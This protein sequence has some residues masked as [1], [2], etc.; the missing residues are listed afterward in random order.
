MKQ[1]DEYVLTLIKHVLICITIFQV[2][3]SCFQWKNDRGPLDRHLP[4]A[5]ALSSVP[6]S[7]SGPVL[8][9]VTESPGPA[10]TGPWPRRPGSPP[11]P[12]ARALPPFPARS[13]GFRR[14][15]RCPP[16]RQVSGFYSHARR[17]FTV[18]VKFK[19]VHLEPWYPWYHSLTYDIIVLPMIS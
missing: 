17:A 10:P 9:A 12:A 2:A 6:R 4:G 15:R 14:G 8:P 7:V 13:P 19:S 16:G 1:N 11:G 5:R 3:D 18:W